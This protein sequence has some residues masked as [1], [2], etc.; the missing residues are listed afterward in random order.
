MAFLTVN[1]KTSVV[2]RGFGCEAKI[3]H[4]SY[5]F[6]GASERLIKSDISHRIMLKLSLQVHSG[7]D[8]R[9]YYNNIKDL[10]CDSRCFQE[11]ECFPHPWLALHNTNAFNWSCDSRQA[12]PAFNWQL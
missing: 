3:G 9:D 5:Q 6:E 1:K 2:K 4:N 7:V 8:L 12:S 10:K 11:N